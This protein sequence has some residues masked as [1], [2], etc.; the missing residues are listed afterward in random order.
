MNQEKSKILLPD[1][2]RDSLDLRLLCWHFGTY[3]DGLEEHGV[4]LADLP[5]DLRAIECFNT[6]C[7]GMRSNGS[8]TSLRNLVALEGLNFTKTFLENAAKGADLVKFSSS[9][10][11]NP[12]LAEL[13]WL[14][15]I[16]KRAGNL[17]DDYDQKI[18]LLEGVNRIFGRLSTFFPPDKVYFLKNLP[19]EVADFLIKSEENSEEELDCASAKTYAYL[20]QHMDIQFVAEIDMERHLEAVAREFRNKEKVGLF[21][22]LS[23]R[24]Q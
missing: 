8:R 15:A 22:R 2:L 11:G 1:Q 10:F 6:A 12:F 7:G 14:D 5:K 16:G 9:H 24:L 13:E 4:T 19:I 17:L 21:H 20:M 18:H 23:A 3:L